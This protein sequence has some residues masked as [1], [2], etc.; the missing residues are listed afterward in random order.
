MS[1]NKPIGSEN[2]G[3]KDKHFKSS[4]LTAQNGMKSFY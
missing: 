1:K 4:P 2:F 3:L